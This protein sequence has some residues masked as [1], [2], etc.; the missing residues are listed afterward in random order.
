VFH[1]YPTIGSTNE[2][3]MALA[4][5]GAPDGT[6]VVAEEQTAGRG[7][8][9]RSWFTPPGSAIALSIVLRLRS[10]TPEAV[11]G[12]SAVGAL[13]VAEALEDLGAAALIKWP[14]DVLLGGRKVAGVLVEGSWS[15]PDLEYVV[16]GIGVNTGPASVPAQPGYPATCVETM[17]GRT[18]DRHDLVARILDRLGRWLPLLGSADLVDAW[19]RRL[20]FRGRDVSVVDE[21]GREEMRG[22]VEGLL[23]DGRLRL[24]TGE[25]ALRVARPEGAHLRPVDTDAA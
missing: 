6:V 25:G 23:A 5:Q 17:V 19:E 4:R 13:A 12:L 9:G 11:G 18:V 20:A 16:I 1:F 3:A 10:I 8:A 24:R 22:A 15:G 14:N 7:R 21:T 2:E